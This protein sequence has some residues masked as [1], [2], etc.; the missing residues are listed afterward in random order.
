MDASFDQLCD[1][2]QNATGPAASVIAYDAVI[3][4]RERLTQLKRLLA[5]LLQQSAKPCRVIIV[6]ASDSPSSTR[7]A[8]ERDIPPLWQA[9]TVVVPSSHRNQPYQ[10]WVGYRLSQSPILAYFDDD[11]VPLAGDI[12]A[13]VL[14]LFVESDVVGAGV[15]IDYHNP[16]VQDAE[17]R[18]FTPKLRT[19]KLLGLFQK[20]IDWV[21][22]LPTPCPGA[23]GLCGVRGALPN[24]E[25]FD[26]EWLPGPFMAFR[27]EALKDS[28]FEKDLFAVFEKR[29]GIGEDAAISY[30][31]GARGRLRMLGGIMLSHPGDA[32]TS[33]Y[34]AATRSFARAV[35]YSRLMLSALVARR[36]G[37]SSLCYRTH[38][39][40]YALFRCLGAAIRALVAPS[41]KRWEYLYGWVEG[42]FTTLLKA[43]THEAWTP[44]IDWEGDAKSDCSRASVLWDGK[45]TVYSTG[46]PQTHADGRKL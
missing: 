44:G 14:R 39:Y 7:E 33:A 36:K 20:A 27:R 19:S 10:R 28:D 9:Q 3:C 24:T 43:P 11:V 40:W 35:A 18:S 16:L 21:T 15:R 45:R 1:K 17:L 32:P 22:G 6:D 37:M 4:T 38:Y 46:I 25:S 13:N 2:T 34:P 30:T 31:V 5:A 23:I 8:L 29:I 12:M 26:V 42:V 41:R